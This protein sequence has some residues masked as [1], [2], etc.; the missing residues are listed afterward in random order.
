MRI[1]HVVSLSLVFALATPAFAQQASELDTLI[2][3]SQEEAQD[4]AREHAAELRR[5]IDEAGRLREQIQAIKSD[6]DS[7]SS[8]R[9]RRLIFSA[10]FVAAFVAVARVKPQ[11][12]DITGPMATFAK[13]IG[14]G[15][16]GVGAIGFGGAATYTHFG[17][18]VKDKNKLLQLE[19]QLAE[20]QRLLNERLA[21]LN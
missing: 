13:L 20:V 1:R 12:G 18:V 10:A 5:L 3:E 7:A 8:R 21:A 4:A 17:V 16:T 6:I 9:N 11:G 15:V 2:Q 19:V 14:M